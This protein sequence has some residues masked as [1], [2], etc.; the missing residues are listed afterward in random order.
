MSTAGRVLYVAVCAAPP[1]SD[2]GA[3][4]ELAQADGWDVCVIATPNAFKFLD[5]P[6]LQAQTGHPVRS[7]YKGP[8]EPDVLPAPTAIVVA[9]ATF[10]TINKWALGISDTLVLGLLTEGIGKGLPLVAM[11]FLNRAQAAHPAFER[12]VAQLRAWG[13]RVLY[14][15]DVFELHEPGTGAQ[16]V[17]LFP[18]RL[19]LAEVTG[20]T[21]G[22]ELA[23][24]V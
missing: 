20:S 17:H 12:S 11:P 19:V 24:G 18:W 13:V 2:V 14:G 16:R 9:P 8:A 7:D 4:V 23:D 1:A 5:V 10:N 22:Q 21:A 15:A 6:K 3:L